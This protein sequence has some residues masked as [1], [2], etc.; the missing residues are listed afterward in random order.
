MSEKS[1]WL[2]KKSSIENLLKLSPMKV[3]HDLTMT[4]L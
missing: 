3:N 4:S 1:N 2:K